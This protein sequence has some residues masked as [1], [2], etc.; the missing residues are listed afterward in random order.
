MKTLQQVRAEL[1]Q[2]YPG[3]SVSIGATAWHHD[4]H[5]EPPTV[6]TQFNGSIHF[7]KGRD[8]PKQIA[9]C[10]FLNSLDDVADGLV[11]QAEAHFRTPSDEPLE[12]GPEPPVDAAPKGES[13]S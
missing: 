7:A 13:Q 8:M 11:A 5:G 10:A 12:V 2:K 1:V 3:C 6:T 9:H 4:N